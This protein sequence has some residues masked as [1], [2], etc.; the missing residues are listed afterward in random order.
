MASGYDG[1]VRINTKIDVRKA[2]SNLLTL[3]NSMD[4]T[5][6][7]ITELQKKLAELG[8]QQIPTDA[9]KTLEKDIESTSKKLGVAKQK[10]DKFLEM[11]PGDNSSVAFRNL[12]YNIAELE[13]K[14]WDAQEA[15]QA[16]V[17][18][19]AAYYQ[20]TEAAEYKKVTAAID[21]K[22]KKLSV[23]NKRYTEY[24]DKQKQ[25]GSLTGTLVSRFKGLALSLLL[26]NQIT[27]VFNAMVKGIKEGL[28]NYAKYSNEY[29]ESVSQLLGSL[30]TLKNALGAAFAP[31]IQVVV[32]ILNSFINS[33]IG[34]VNWI[35]QLI[36]AL[37]G[38][39]TWSKATKQIKDYRKSLDGAAESAKKS[40][41]GFD[42]L[43]VLNDSNGSSGG[44][45][46]SGPMYTEEEISGPISN[47]AAKIKKFLEPLKNWAIDEALPAT[48]NLLSTAFEILC[49]VLE[50]LEPLFV[51]AWESF[52]VPLASWTGDTIVNAINSLTNLLERLWKEVLVPFIDWFIANILPVIEPVLDAIKVVFKDL[53]DVITI[54]INTAIEVLS[55]IITFLAG[56]FS[57]DVSKIMEGISQIISS[58]WNGLVNIV[59]IA[60]G[61]I[62]SIVKATFETI[63]NTIATIIKAIRTIISTGM[64]LIKTSWS[65][66]F[67]VLRNTTQSI[68]NGIWNTIKRIINSILGGIE[69]M[70][71]GVVNG[72]NT[73]VDALN[74]L[75][76]TVPDWV[77]GIGGK[78]W[79]M[80]IPR[81]ATVSL[82]RLATGGIT[83]G[84][85]I[86][87]IG[88]AGKEAVLPLENNTGWMDSL[89]EKINGGGNARYTF[90]AQLN[91][92][93]LFEETVRQDELYAQ[94]KGHG[95]FVY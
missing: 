82:P 47:M 26:F 86:A 63:G 5:D 55:G 24:V 91:G 39:A 88:E 53:L 92:K 6:K 73:V 68:F 14:L 50:Y 38:K 77:P 89:A 12:Q 75:S 11:N 57:G 64:N 36:A 21:E 69:G 76:F 32:P 80:N 18:N 61:S 52:F 49:G 90:V 7:E 25:A 35:G 40:L 42:E 93:T 34:A 67:T 58:T 43:N 30:A 19:G 16:L 4:K 45:A 66:G 62:A 59:D 10:M 48:I 2:T 15:Q 81:M 13:N 79:S 95:A 28:Q 17:N 54:V 71:N 27:K 41:A 33:L 83:T 70:A 74:G 51:W 84:R 94:A 72:V 29:N 87:E 1:Y 8:E 3:Q 9:F 46:S 85:T 65:N 22:Q 56:V 44:G 20:G 31:L 37:T 78:S 23:L 60:V